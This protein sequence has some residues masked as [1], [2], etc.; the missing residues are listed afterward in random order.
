MKAYIKFNLDSIKIIIKLQ[1][2]I[3]MIII[4]SIKSL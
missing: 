4:F 2:I 1:I 3:F